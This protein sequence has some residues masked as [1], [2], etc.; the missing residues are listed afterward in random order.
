MLETVIRGASVVLPEGRVTADVEIGDGVISSITSAGELDGGRVL[1]ADGYVLVPGAIGARVHVHTQFGE[2]LTT[3][4]DFWTATVPAAL[5]GTTTIVE[6]TIQSRRRRPRTPLT[7]ASR[8]HTRPPRVDYALHAY[9]SREA[10]DVSLEQ[11]RALA[12]RGVQSVKVFSAYRG[13]IGLS[14]DEWGVSCAARRRS[15]CS[16]SCTPRTTR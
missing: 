1:E 6:L 4:D 7:A 10:F 14:L 2:W 11:L 9:V 3:R 13:T 16:F 12:S 8:R 5:S 15:D